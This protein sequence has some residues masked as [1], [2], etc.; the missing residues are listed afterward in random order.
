MKSLILTLLFTLALPFAA[1]A[2]EDN[3]ME[4]AA[5]PLSLK[6]QRIETQ[7]TYETPSDPSYIDRAL[8]MPLEEQVKQWA[9]RNLFAVG[10]DRFLKI[11]IQR[12]SVQESFFE[13]EKRMFG[14]M[15]GPQMTRYTLELM[16]D[17]KVYAPDKN[18]PEATVQV[19][20]E[21][22]GVMET[23]APIAKHE[24]MMSD[25]TDKLLEDF[26]RQARDSMTRYF[27]SYIEM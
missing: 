1:M 16:A 7:S 10:R 25:L 3:T 24:T 12:A 22:S 26:N 13:G 9:N 18:L 20:V 4:G 6:V 27:G 15:K 23:N 11:D 21:Q 5:K 2:Q 8:P 17:F 19:K 14:L